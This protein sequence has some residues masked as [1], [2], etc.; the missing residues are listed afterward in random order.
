MFSSIK[1]Q[2]QK[3]YTYLLRNIVTNKKGS[4]KGDSLKTSIHKDSAWLKLKLMNSK[5]SSLSF[6]HSGISK[7]S[8]MGVI[9]L[10]SSEAI[11]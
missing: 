5:M 7:T 10:T 1:E 6:V 3:I 9:I 11:K 4:I 8:K 2:T